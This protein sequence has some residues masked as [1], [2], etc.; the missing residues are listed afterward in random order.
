[1]GIK[2][3]IIT[4]ICVLLLVSVAGC[5]DQPKNAT[6]DDFYIITKNSDNKFDYTFEDKNGNILFEQKDSV[7]SPRIREVTPG[8][9]ELNTQTGTGLSTNWAVY[10]DI[11]NSKTSEVFKYVLGAKDSFVVYADYENKAHTIVVQNIFDKSHYCETYELKNESPKP[12]KVIYHCEFNDNGDFEVTY[13]TGE[14]Y[15]KTPVTIDIP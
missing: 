7:K 11:E 13:C 15:T 1:M 8:V 3:I 5:S 6:L 2:K 4:L 9:Y 10:C 14:N 12:E